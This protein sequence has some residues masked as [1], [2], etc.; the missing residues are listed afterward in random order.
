MTL[1]N[2]FMKSYSH[3]IYC[4]SWAVS[5]VLGCFVIMMMIDT[6]WNSAYR[7]GWNDAMENK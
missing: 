7:K 4:W 5:F 6:A 3:E 2:N 1:V